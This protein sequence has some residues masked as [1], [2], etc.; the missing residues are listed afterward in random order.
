MHTF[1]EGTVHAFKLLNETDF[2]VTLAKPAPAELEEGDA[3]ENLTWAPDLKIRG[4][5][6][7][8]CRA[9]G[10]LVTTPGTVVI[11][12]N[13]FE[14]SGSA[15]LISGDAN[16]W[17]ESGGVRD[18]FIRGNTFKAPCLT[19]LYQ[20]CEGVISI[21]PIIP[22]PEKASAPFHRNIRIENN[23]FH[24]FDYPVLY[25]KSVGGLSFIENRIIRSHKYEPYHHR[26]HMLSLEYCQDVTVSGNA[27][28]GDVLGCDVHL[29]HMPKS[30]MRV[31]PGQG[32]A[33]P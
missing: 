6:F 33:G 26:Q 18:V 12:D 24:M 19:N 32:I 8:S 21:L 20:F 17:Y 28:E 3:L 25:A 5:K 9:R 10:L 1:A 31:E 14:S 15:I 30:E 4:C 11:E 7:G 13:V 27:F 16:G 22:K 23:V 2:E 29:Q